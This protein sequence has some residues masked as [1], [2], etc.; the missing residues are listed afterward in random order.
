MK[1]LSTHWQEIVVGLIVG[2]A[3]LRVMQSVLKQWQSMNKKG[4]NSCGDG[5]GCGTSSK[6]ESRPSLVQ[7][8]RSKSGL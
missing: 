3:A 2:F 5:C 8:K 7:I 6:E 1:F 4:S